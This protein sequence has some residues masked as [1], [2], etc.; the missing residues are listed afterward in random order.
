MTSERWALWVL[1][2]VLTCGLTAWIVWR[3]DSP[4][5]APATDIPVVIRT[6]GGLLE[7]ANVKHRRLFKLAMDHTLFG[8]RVPVCRERTSYEVDAVITYRV[9]LAT[10]WKGDLEGGRLFLTV[11]P[12]VPA[13]PVAF[14]TSR[15]TATFRACSFVPSMKTKDRLLRSISGTLAADA[16]GPRYAALAR[17]AARKTVEEFARK[18]VLGQSRYDTLA[19]ST[20]IEVAFS[21]E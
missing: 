3:P 14:D 21:D 4:D 5:P 18:W 6:N 15:L 16:R 2:L 10:R 19:R 11:P 17:N 20:P 1:S 9:K 13:I 7:V 8:K 12:P